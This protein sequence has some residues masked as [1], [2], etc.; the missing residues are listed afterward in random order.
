MVAALVLQLIFLSYGKEA[1]EQMGL[2]TETL[3]AE[4]EPPSSSYK[5]PPFP[6]WRGLSP[7]DAYQVM[8]Q[9]GARI[10]QET[11]R[12]ERMEMMKAKRAARERAKLARQKRTLERMADVAAQEARNDV[13]ARLEALRNATAPAARAAAAAA[14]DAEAARQ[15]ADLDDRKREKFNII[16]VRRLA[17]EAATPIVLNAITNKEDEILH[18]GEVAG[19]RAAIANANSTLQQIKDEHTKWTFRSDCEFKAF[20]GTA[21]AWQ[22][23]ENKLLA[24]VEELA[25]SVAS[26]AEKKA[27]IVVLRNVSAGNRTNVS[28]VNISAE[29]VS[30]EQAEA[31]NNPRGVLPSVRDAA[32]AAR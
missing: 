10:R 22:E 15:K 23:G 13:F 21:A 19:V 11:A 24:W 25:E 20:D 3:S 12:N 6:A 2:R 18:A 32:N 28:A 26:A 9:R 31:A 1:L 8:A 7:Q 4:A 30:A 14:A 27:F 17:E 16:H 5:R 29:D